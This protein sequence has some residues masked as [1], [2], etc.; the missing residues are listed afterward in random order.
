MSYVSI[1]LNQSSQDAL[2]A[3]NPMPTWDWKG[4]HMTIHMGPPNKSDLMMVG[5]RVM[6]TATHFGMLHGRVAALKIGAGGQ[7][8]QNEIPHVT[9][10]VN[11]RVGAKPVES[12]N[13]VNWTKLY[14]PITLVGNYTIN[15]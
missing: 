2:F 4:H 10:C 14:L 8:S 11:G 7:Y 1:V 13:I 6:L 3:R 15:Q 9:L 5:K 12:N